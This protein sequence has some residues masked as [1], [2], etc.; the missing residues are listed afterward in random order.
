M[1]ID[2]SKN[3]KVVGI[4]ESGLDYYYE[5]SPRDEQRKSFLTHIEAARETGLPLVVHSRDADDEMADILRYA[6]RGN[7]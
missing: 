1:L 5:H 6:P 4:G 2:L 3:D 7:C